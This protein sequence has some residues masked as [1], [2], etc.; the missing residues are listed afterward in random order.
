MGSDMFVDRGDQAALRFNCISGVAMATGDA[1]YATFFI[2][3]TKWASC[4]WQLSHTGN[5][6]WK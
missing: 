2:Q 5:P 3:Q 4:I 6:W 1:V